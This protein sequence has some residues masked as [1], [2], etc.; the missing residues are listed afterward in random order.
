MVE[1]GKILIRLWK[2]D[3]IDV[4]E[5]GPGDYTEVGPNQFHRFEALEDSICYELYWS[6]LN[7]NDI[8]REDTG[9]RS[10][11]DPGQT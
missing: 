1:S 3:T 11:K 10:I 8:V 6:E 5:L 9:G 4:T 2:P 7:P